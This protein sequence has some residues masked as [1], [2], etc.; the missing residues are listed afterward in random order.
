MPSSDSS[1]ICRSFEFVCQR[2]CPLVPREVALLAEL[3]GERE[4]LRLPWLGKHGIAFVAR[5]RSTFSSGVLKV[6]VPHIQ[7]NEIADLCLRAPEFA[8]RESN[9]V[10]MLPLLALEMRVGIGERVDAMIALNDR[11]LC[12]WHNAAVAYAPVGFIVTSTHAVDPF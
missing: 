12:L 6:V 8:S 2:G 3:N 4:G 11:P 7:M 10:N 9:R 1:A 5:R